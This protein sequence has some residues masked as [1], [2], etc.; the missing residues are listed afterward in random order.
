[1]E[2]TDVKSIMSKMTAAEIEAYLAEAKKREKSEYAEKKKQYEAYRDKMV[3]EMVSEAEELNKK[4]AAAKAKWMNGLKKFMEKA[5]KYGDVRSNSKGGY[6]LRTS[7]S[8]KLVVYEHN[9][10][11]EY[12]ERADMAENLLREFLEDMVKKADKKSYNVIVSLM[13]RNKRGDFNTSRINSLLSIKDN[14]DDERWQRAMKLFEESYNNRIISNSVS[15]YK[16]DENGKDQHIS[17]NLTSL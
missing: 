10:K 8:K 17:L 7:D 13:S 2:K 11:P 6:S 14:Y 9:S 5:R 1:M 16:Q 4:L 12:D 3:R 15:F